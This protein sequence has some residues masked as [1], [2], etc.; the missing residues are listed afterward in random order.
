MRRWEI[1]TF[2]GYHRGECPVRSLPLPVTGTRFGHRNVILGLSPAQK[3][4]SACL[5]ASL[6]PCLA[7]TWQVRRL[8]KG[9]L[10][11]LCPVWYGNVSGHS[12]SSELTTPSRE[13]MRV[14]GVARSRNTSNTE[15]RTRENDDSCQYRLSAAIC[16]HSYSP[17]S[18]VP[19]FS[20][21]LGPLCPPLRHRRAL[22]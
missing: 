19:C 22:G 14:K 1:V 12:A 17:T 18:I 2:E 4:P 3:R 20:T 10:K 11:R 16:P 5:M 7:S 13:C 15:T 9:K 21:L 6:A 8:Q